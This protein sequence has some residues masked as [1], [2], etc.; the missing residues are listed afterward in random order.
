MSYEM[1]F[2]WGKTLLL[3]SGVAEAELDARYLL[4]ECCHISHVEF[5]TNKKDYVPREQEEAYKAAIRRRIERVP[6]QYI[7]GKQEFMGLPFRVNPSVLVPRQDTEVLVE[8]VLH[9]CGNKHVLDLCTGSG[10]IA[11]S[12][13]KL[14]GCASVTASDIS[15]EALSV[16]KENAAINQVPVRFVMSD[17]FEKIEN[18]FDIIV[19]NPPYIP[20]GVLE[21]LMPEVSKYEPRIALDGLED[22]L[23]FYREIIRQADGYLTAAGALYF[24][25]G[26]DQGDQVRLLME[27][28]G[29][30]NIE[31]VKDYTGMDRVIRG[32]R[33]GSYL[34]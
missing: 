23:H 13:A 20:T 30:S 17:L 31:I 8:T 9:V 7:T 33:P 34:D 12:L 11:V 14:G 16:A 21:T 2:L 19:S 26:Y 15:A 4:E 6:L 1:L 29:Y 28:A 3:K 25:I 24:E 32:D 22:G 18:S 5:L 27:E 10:C